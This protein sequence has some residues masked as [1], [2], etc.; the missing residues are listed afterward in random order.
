MT[1]ICLDAGHYGKY[2]RSPAVNSYYESEVMWKLHLYQKKHLESYGIEVIITRPEQ[3]KDLSLYNRGITS[4]GC[5]LFLSNHSNAVG[6]E[7]N[8]SVD[9]PVAYTAVNGAADRIATLLTECVERVMDTKQNARINKRKNSSGSDY[10]GVVRGAT[11]VGVPGLI[12]E[13]SFHTNT[14]STNWL[15]NDNNL[16]RLAKEEAKVIAEYFGI[17]NETPGNDKWYRIRQ[18]WNK[19]ESHI[20]AYKNL[21]NA[22]AACKPG[23]TVYDWNGNAIYTLED[24]PWVGQC[25]GNSVNVR[26][27]PGMGYSNIEGW[28]TL[29]KGNLFDVIG[30]EGAWYFILIDKQYKGYISQQYVKR[31]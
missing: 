29:D 5:D 25:T 11:A 16:D 4:K 27:G 14:R 8:E 13:H 30:K 31:V 3:A 2:N 19:P 9:Y 6:N 28:P 17:N 24:Y 10:Y 12:L 22:K 23:Y 7:V 26:K 15:L 20:G 1:K 21:S 18:S